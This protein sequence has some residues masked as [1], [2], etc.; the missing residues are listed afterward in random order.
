MY[1]IYKLYIKYLDNPG[2]QSKKYFE[3]TIFGSN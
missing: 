2:I 3:K 1:L